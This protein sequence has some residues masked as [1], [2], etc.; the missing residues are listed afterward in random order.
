MT[1]STDQAGREAVQQ[2]IAYL[3]KAIYL[4]GE[5]ELLIEAIDRARHALLYIPKDGTEDA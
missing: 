1:K 3:H 4:V 2:A 5:E